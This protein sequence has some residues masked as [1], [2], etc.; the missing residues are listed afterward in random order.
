MKTETQNIMEQ[1]SEAMN[2]ATTTRRT[3]YVFRHDERWWYSG[4]LPHD[5]AEFYIAYPSGDTGTVSTCAPEL[6]SDDWNAFRLTHGGKLQPTGPRKKRLANK[7]T[8]ATKG[9]RRLMSH[10]KTIF[11]GLLRLRR[12][13]IAFCLCALLASM[14]GI[15]NADLWPLAMPVCLVCIPLTLLWIV[16]ALH[17]APFGVRRN[18]RRMPHW[19]SKPIF[20]FYV[21]LAMIAMHKT[22]D[23][24]LFL[25][26]LVGSLAF[27]GRRAAV[28]VAGLSAED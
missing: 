12:P 1:L 17:R 3:M 16:C 15:A 4:K 2:G 8:R 6:T 20:A 26:T 10:F 13:H 11:H 5:A 19:R 21:H 22:D 27:S 28:V 23:S 24:G 7:K 25:F 18:S 14:G 9:S